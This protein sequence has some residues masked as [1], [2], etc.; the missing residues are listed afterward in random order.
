[1]THQPLDLLGKLGH[2]RIQQRIREARNSK[3]VG[4]IVVELDP[5]SFCDLEC[6]NCITMDVLNQSRF[7]AERLSKFPAEL[8]EMGVMAVILIG[9]GEPLIHPNTPRLIAGLREHKIKTGLVTNGTMIH[10]YVDLLAKSCEWIR[11]SMDAGSPDT[12]ARVRP[13][14]TTGS[15]LKTFERIIDGIRKIAEIDPATRGTVGYSFV[16]QSG[17]TAQQGSR[18]I[19]DIMAATAL[20]KQL[21]CDYIEFKAEMQ[22][23]HQIMALSE[24]DRGKIRQSLTNARM[25]ASD[26]FKVEFSSSMLAAQSAEEQTGQIKNYASCPVADLRTTISPSGCFVCS[27]HRGNSAHRYGDVAIR[28]FNEVWRERSITTRPNSDCN[29]H[30]ARH[31][32]NEAL[33]V[34]NEDSIPP[35][36]ESRSSPRSSGDLFI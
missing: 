19:D 4:P 21:G 11:I 27:Y 34:S 35:T 15:S 10:R 1:M 22:P 6:P 13:Q 25:L 33:L 18:N 31:E 29:F 23:N 2:P 32:V 8:A 24:I 20:A 17:Y 30:C 5:T 9:G 26:S 14:R 12:Y 36:G 28:P 16:I 3:T 7:S